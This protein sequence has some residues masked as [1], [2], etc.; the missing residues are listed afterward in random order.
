MKN[1]FSLTIIMLLA[2]CL[3][4]VISYAQEKILTFSEFLENV[5]TSN[6]NYLVERYNVD[7]AKA[8]VKAAKVFPDPNLTLG[9]A[10]N[11]HWDLEMGYSYE[12]GL[13]YNLELG[14]KRKARIKVAQSE[15]ELVGAQ[16]EDYFRNLRA[17][18]TLAYLLALKQK[19]L[20][21][22]QKYSYQY[23]VDL[24]QAADTRFKSGAITEVDAHQ[25][26]LEAESMFNNMLS[27]ESDL[28]DALIQL[29]FMQGNREMQLP[30]S[31]S[32]ELKYFKREYDLLSLITTAQNNRADLQVALKSKEVSQN[33][34]KLAKANRVIDLG[35]NL[36]VSYNAES[37]NEIAPA[38]AFTGVSGGISIPLK[39]SNTNK[40]EVNA[41]KLAL[42]QSESN[43]EA[44]ELQIKS[45]VTQ[46]YHKY[47]IACR[48]VDQFNTDLLY[49]ARNI[50]QKQMYGYEKGET[51]ILELLHAQR[52]YNDVQ[53][54]Y[55]ETLYNCAAALIELQRAVGIWDIEM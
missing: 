27:K 2:F 21:E 49:L 10:N 22:T 28:Q 38:P 15:A 45:E 39:F 36:G 17:D 44:V 47:K 40:G 48:Q 11:Q 23:M 31:L 5:K 52:A 50:F 14:G 1:K 16:L 18:A 3:W 4:P 26:K 42:Q 12:A 24:A 35:L 33:I 46:A 7:I 25:S 55:N 34:L 54:H 8:N 51:S 53:V 37:R 19:K 20:L 13:D 9:G 41:A 29:A 43:Y 32:G 6:I 30:D